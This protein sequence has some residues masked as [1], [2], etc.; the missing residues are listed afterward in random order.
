MPQLL[1]LDASMRWSGSVSREVS[2]AF[3]EHWR[4][5]HPHG[6]VVY[7]DLAVDPVPHLDHDSFTAAMTPPE[8]HTA[9]QRAGW[10]V[11]K[12]LIAEVE[13]ADTVLI[14]V[15]MYNFS[16]PSTLK[17]WLDR[18]VTPATSADRETGVGPFSDKKFVIAAARGGAYGPGTPRESFEFQE[19]LLRSILGS[20]LGIKDLTFVNT[21]MTLVDVDP[22]LA[23]FKDFA[24]ESRENAHKAVRELATERTSR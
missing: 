18:I 9:A 19:R 22:G 23:Q 8:D 17:A 14:G 10:A 12:A 13:A 11:S 24:A 2:A 5:A 16:V 4:A 20:S 1:H 3:A 6:T 7:R 21:E 15:P